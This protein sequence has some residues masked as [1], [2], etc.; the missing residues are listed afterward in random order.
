MAT[1]LHPAAGARA[2]RRRA[3]APEGGLGLGL[4][5]GGARARPAAPPP[6][7]VAREQDPSQRI[8][9]TGQGVAS[10]F[11]NDPAAFY[12]ALLAGRSG[13]SLIDRFDASEYPTRFAGQIKG[14]E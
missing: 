1:G 5:G 7:A 10:V 3:C 11:G 14:F 6:R 4:G 2:A 13:V 9:I 8:V 12:D